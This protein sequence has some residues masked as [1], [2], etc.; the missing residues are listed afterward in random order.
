ANTVTV[1]LDAN[2]LSALENVTVT[3]GAAVS[4]ANFPATQQVAGTVTIGN[5][6]TISSLPAIS[7][8]VTANVF[9]KS[10]SNQDFYPIPVN[11][12]GNSDN[13]LRH[14]PIGFVNNGDSTIISNN[15]PL[16]ISGT[17]TANVFQG[18]F[19]IATFAGYFDGT[20]Q[21]ERI[22]NRSYYC[23]S[24]DFGGI[25]LIFDEESGLWNF[26][27]NNEGLQATNE[28]GSFLPPKTGWNIS[29]D[30]SSL[31]ISYESPFTQP[32]SGT[33]TANV[34]G[35]DGANNEFVPIT[36]LQANEGLGSTSYVVGVQVANVNGHITSS[37]PPPPPLAELPG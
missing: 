21:L 14:I 10:S 18:Q 2:S 28:S 30:I 11:E 37:N 24:N 35:F 12:S 22:G 9:G 36:T 23:N 34:F 8:T 25:S 4:V 31:S 17:V 13:L 6:V 1:A 29:G 15:S 27:F 7:G 20:Y 19:I 26:Y 16:P 33:V 5:S 32:I 3:V